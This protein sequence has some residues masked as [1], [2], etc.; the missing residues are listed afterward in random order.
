MF[1]ISIEEKQNKIQIYNENILIIEETS[2]TKIVL[3]IKKLKNIIQDE[4]QLNVLNKILN[5]I[6]LSEVS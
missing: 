6:K 1:N 4:Y 2:Y 3:I 5:V